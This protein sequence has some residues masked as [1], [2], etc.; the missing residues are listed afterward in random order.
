MTISELTRL[1]YPTYPRGDLEGSRTVTLMARV[2]EASRSPLALRAACWD[3]H[4]NDRYSWFSILPSD[5]MH[6]VQDLVR[7]PQGQQSPGSLFPSDS[8]VFIPPLVDRSTGLVL[9][10]DGSYVVFKLG[11]AC[12]KIISA[13]GQVITTIGDDE[14]MGYEAARAG[15][16]LAGPSCMA[17]NDREEIYVT[18]FSN[19]Q[20]AVFDANGAFVEFFGRSLLVAFW[21]CPEWPGHLCF[22]RQA[23][24]NLP[25]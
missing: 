4:K 3:L 12:M 14:I 25:I 16:G 21:D 7:P 2:D 8:P 6:I 15:K 13:A 5:I 24:K 18:E 17:I 23:Q 9:R 11:G 1:S 19:Q 20:V 22:L 10:Q